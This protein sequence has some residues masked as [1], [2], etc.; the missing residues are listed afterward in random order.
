MPG[1]GLSHDEFLRKKLQEWTTHIKQMFSVAV[2][3]SARWHDLDAIIQVL[4][5]IGDDELG[6]LFFP[7]GGGLNFAGAARAGGEPGCIDLLFTGASDYIVKPGTLSFESPA[8]DLQW[9]YFRLEA[10]AMLPSGIYDDTDNDYEV[11][12]RFGPGDYGP[13]AWYEDGY[14]FEHGEEVRVPPGTTR[15][16]RYLKPCS[17]VIFARGSLYSGNPDTYDARHNDM[18]AA[19]FRNYIAETAAHI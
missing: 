17:F 5:Y 4:N 19:E 1:E 12:T 2:P 3:D 16:T 13:Q 9:A 6:H 14:Y 7:T 18:T 8:D 15:A 11:V 10:D